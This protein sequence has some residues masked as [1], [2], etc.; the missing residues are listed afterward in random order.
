MIQKLGALQ[1]EIKK[2]SNSTFKLSILKVNGVPLYYGAVALV[3][4]IKGLF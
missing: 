3:V 4:S 1:K 2:G